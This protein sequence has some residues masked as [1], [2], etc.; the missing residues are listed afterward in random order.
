MTSK[1]YVFPIL[2]GIL[3]LYSWISFIDVEGLTAIRN[4]HCNK[5]KFGNSKCQIIWKMES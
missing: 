3:K 1:S 2:Q 5:S 4:H